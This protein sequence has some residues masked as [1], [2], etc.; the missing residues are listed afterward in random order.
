MLRQRFRNHYFLPLAVGQCLHHSVFQM[1]DTHHIDGFSHNI[2][3]VGVELSPE[4]CVGHTPHS[5]HFGNAKVLHIGLVGEHDADVLRT[6]ALRKQVDVAPIEQKPSAEFG[7]KACQGLQ[8]GRLAD[9]VRTYQTGKLATLYFY[10]Y[11]GYY[12]RKAFVA[13]R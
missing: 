13:H 1:V 10:I 11:A 7:Q 2:S 3:V 6:F 4:A 9:A 12:G 8:Q 5:H